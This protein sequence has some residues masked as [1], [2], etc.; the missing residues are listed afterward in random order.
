MFRDRR[1]AGRKLAEALGRYAG[2]EV[3]VL[4]LP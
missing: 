2:R 4:A 1:D 3:A